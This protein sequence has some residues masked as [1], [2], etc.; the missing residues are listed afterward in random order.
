MSIKQSTQ[1]AFGI[2][3][4]LHVLF[5]SFFIASALSPPPPMPIP[6]KLAV[7]SIA[8]LPSS[9]HHRTVIT[10]AAPPAAAQ[11][12]GGKKEEPPAPPSV[13]KHEQSA[14][15]EVALCTPEEPP[16]VTEV[17]SAEPPA[18]PP[19]KPSA[20]KTAHSTKAAP[21]KSSSKTASPT[22]KGKAASSQKPKAAPSGS[23]QSSSKP[24]GKKATTSQ[25]PSYDQKLL[26]EALQRL[27]KSKSAAAMGSGSG[28]S[29]GGGG[30]GSSKAVARVG[31]V[32]SLNVEQGLVAEN[33]EAQDSAFE[34]Y[35]SASPEAYYIGDLIRRLQLN[36]R[37]PEPGEVRVRLTLNRT[38]AVTHVQVLS[39][40][41]SSVKHT[42][43]EKL[44]T[45]HFSYFG[46]SFSGETE[47][48]FS[49]RLSNELLWSCS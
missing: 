38:G 28:S 35:S 19:P 33:S 40:K 44:R 17:P 12:A 27:D 25:A 14:S 3:L 22:A 34:G 47:H 29:V 26:S 10:A 37:L 13:E 39:G 30:G 43:E 8:L 16:A 23:K 4:S 24:S 45:I 36:I 5:I 15:A 49:L 21:A 7:Q 1:K 41:S 2:S 18:P 20:Q 46:G 11:P 32:G 9:R 42:I 31:S 48:T 6:H